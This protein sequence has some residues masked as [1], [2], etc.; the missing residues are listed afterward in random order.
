MLYNL[1]FTSGMLC[2]DT[3]EGGNRLSY[4]FNAILLLKWK[5]HFFFFNL[6]DDDSVTS[7][8]SRKLFKYYF[9]KTT[10]NQTT[11]N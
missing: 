7:F 8:L 10:P 3:F 9:K 2:V 11:Q 4:Y 5:F 1:V 6:E